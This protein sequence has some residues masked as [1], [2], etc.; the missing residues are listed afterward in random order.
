MNGAVLTEEQYDR[1]SQVFS[2]DTL[3]TMTP[4]TIDL[5]K[6]ETNLK[7]TEKESYIRIDT[8]YDNDGTLVDQVETEVSEAEALNFGDDEI[9]TYS[10]N[11]THQTNMKRL[12]MQVIANGYASQKVVTLT[13]TW[14]SIPSTKSYDV[15]AL[16]PGSNSMTVNV[17]TSTISGYQKWDGNYVN[18]DKNSDNTKI[19]SSFTGKGGIGISMNIVDSVTSSLENSMTVVFISGADPFKISGTYQHAQ[20]NV[21]LSESKN[22]TFSDKGYGNVLDFASSVKSK[23]DQMQGIELSYSFG[24]ELFG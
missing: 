7:K 6:D 2:E 1:L 3:Y 24:E 19:S 4:E 21:T 20:S 12:H 15:I 23:Y 5:V 22:Y 17:S 18:Y 11:G 14:L 10:W 9:T 8:Y 16:R 13:N